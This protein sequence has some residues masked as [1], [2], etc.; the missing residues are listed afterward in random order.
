MER[1][2]MNRIID[3]KDFQFDEHV[4]VGDIIIINNEYYTITRIT[5]E[6]DDN[7]VPIIKYECDRL[8]TFP[9]TRDMPPFTDHVVIN[10]L[11]HT[12]PFFQ[13]EKEISEDVRKEFMKLLE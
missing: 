7:C 3:Y 9:D 13:T 2:N 5:Y 8:G 10:K 12:E 1:L 6:G 4:Q 11:M